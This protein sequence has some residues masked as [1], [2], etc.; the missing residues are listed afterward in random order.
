[1]TQV[2][3]KDGRSGWLF[4]GTAGPSALA[5]KMNHFH[6]RFASRNFE[7]SVKQANTVPEISVKK[8]RTA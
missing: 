7:D 3:I 5:E 8:T 4:I 1:M 6:H 2:P